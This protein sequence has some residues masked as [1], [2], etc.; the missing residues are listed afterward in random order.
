MKQRL[1][2]HHCTRTSRY[3]SLSKAL[4]REEAVCQ[5]LSP[6]D[7]FT[8]NA[9]SPDW[10]VF[11]TSYVKLYLETTAV[12]ILLC[13]VVVKPKCIRWTLFWTC[14]SIAHQ[15]GGSKRFVMK[16]VLFWFRASHVI[17]WREWRYKRETWTNFKCLKILTFS[18]C[19]ETLSFQFV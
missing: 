15:R 3:F 4:L 1:G 10:H 5:I 6:I 14:M 2:R 18:F 7:T 17:S 8:I 13:K 16:G 19:C 12:I 9:I 11:A